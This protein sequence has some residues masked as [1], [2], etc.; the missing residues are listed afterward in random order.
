MNVYLIMSLI[1]PQSVFASVITKEEAFNFLKNR[2][3]RDNSWLHG[4]ELE[5]GDLGRILQR[6][7]YHRFRA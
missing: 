6:S 2:V 3:R 5:S 4:E 1:M 7:N